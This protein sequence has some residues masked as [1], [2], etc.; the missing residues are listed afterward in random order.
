MT[1]AYLTE[2]GYRTY[3]NTCLLVLMKA[4][5][6][7]KPEAIYNVHQSVNRSTYI[8][9]ENTKVSDGDITSFKSLMNKYIAD[10]VS[11]VAKGFIYAPRRN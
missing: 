1:R 3:R 4:I 2:E 6:K 5:A 8:E 7:I 10:N 11:L 9:F